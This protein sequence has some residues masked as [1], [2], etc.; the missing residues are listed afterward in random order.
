MT[1][2]IWIVKNTYLIIDKAGDDD[3][4]HSCII[5][6]PRVCGYYCKI[7]LCIPARLCIKLHLLYFQ[8]IIKFLKC[9]EPNHIDIE[10]TH[11]YFTV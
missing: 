5:K 7:S 11:I 10:I 4:T 3:E 8:E 2:L 6:I 9:K 1:I